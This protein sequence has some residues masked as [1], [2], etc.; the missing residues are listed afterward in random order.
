MRRV[1]DLYD[2]VGGIRTR[3]SAGIE[4]G[5]DSPTTVSGVRLRHPAG[6]ALSVNLASRCAIRSKRWEEMPPTAVLTPDCQLYPGAC[7]LN[8]LEGEGG[9]NETMNG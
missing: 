9:P 5:E 6:E 2:S 8:I 4:L 3:W 1:L 7:L